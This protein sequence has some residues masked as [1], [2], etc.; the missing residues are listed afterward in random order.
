[1]TTGASQPPPA[2]RGADDP[3]AALRLRSPSQRAFD[4]PALKLGRFRSIPRMRCSERARTSVGSPNLSWA[5][6]RSTWNLCRGCIRSFTAKGPP[7]SHGPPRLRCCRPRNCRGVTHAVHVDRFGA[8][9]DPGA[10]VATGVPRGTSPSG[11][12]NIWPQRRGDD[13]AG[14]ARAALKPMEAIAAPRIAA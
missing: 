1:V 3:P 9:R 6:R 4:S 14:P 10:T 13:I 11:W 8:K 5:E 12:A 2:S 7:C